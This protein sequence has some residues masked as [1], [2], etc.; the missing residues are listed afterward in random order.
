MKN[1]LKS[2]YNHTFKH[3]DI[4]RIQRE[5]FF[6]FFIRGFFIEKL[7]RRDIWNIKEKK[8]EKYNGCFYHSRRPKTKTV[9]VE[10]ANGTHAWFCL[11]SISPFRF[12]G[13]RLTELIN[14]LKHAK[15]IDMLQHVG[16]FDSKFVYTFSY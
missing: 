8:G 11:A 7:G 9:H 12:L 6:I 5:D 13:R 1:T 10:G 3:D 15:L 16:S 4:Y 14:L 2:N